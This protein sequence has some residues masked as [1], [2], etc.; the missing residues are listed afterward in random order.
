[1]FH[2]IIYSKIVMRTFKNSEWKST[3]YKQHICFMSPSRPKENLWWH[4][5]NWEWWRITPLMMQNRSFEKFHYY[6]CHSMLYSSLYSCTWLFHVYVNNWWPNN[7]KE[8]ITQFIKQLSLKVCIP[9]L[10]SNSSS[11][12]SVLRYFSFIVLHQALN[13]IKDAPCLTTSEQLYNYNISN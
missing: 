2:V 6:W 11:I 3:Y 12:K 1:M 13:R 4:Q 8:L 7:G 5:N 10:I 9:P